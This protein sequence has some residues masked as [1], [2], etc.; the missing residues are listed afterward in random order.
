MWG[1]GVCHWF[2]GGLHF[3]VCGGGNV[4]MQV[5]GCECLQDLCMG[6]VYRMTIVIRNSLNILEAF[7]LVFR[8][9]FDCDPLVK[10]ILF[11]HTHTPHMKCT[12]L[13]FH[14]D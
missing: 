2:V 6:D 9:S 8:L 4:N 7:M 14:L 3:I 10:Q 5:C 1:W 13:L 11:K 12:N